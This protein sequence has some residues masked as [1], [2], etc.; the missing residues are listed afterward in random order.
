MKPAYLIQLSLLLLA[1]GLISYHFITFSNTLL[2][3]IVAISVALGN[4][5]LFLKLK[6]VNQN[7]HS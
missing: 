7:S 3:V 2:L 6:Q 5:A 1:V 4:G